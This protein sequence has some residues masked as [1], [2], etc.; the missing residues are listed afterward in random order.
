MRR[1]E[2]SY[3]HRTLHFDKSK[4][5]TNH[6]IRLKEYTPDRSAAS[7]SFAVYLFSSGGKDLEDRPPCDA[8]SKRMSLLLSLGRPNGTVRAPHRDSRLQK[9]PL[10]PSE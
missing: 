9:Q 5:G 1:E 2:L 6:H 3:I 8:Q 4:L 7:F 10:L